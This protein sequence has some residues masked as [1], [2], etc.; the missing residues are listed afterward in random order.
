M[1]CEFPPGAL[2]I[3]RLLTRQTGIQSLD[4]LEISASNVAGR[5]TDD[6]IAERRGVVVFGSSGVG[7][8][9]DGGGLTAFG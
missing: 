1:V 3:I 9:G 4:P 2:Q 8:G 6:R 7:N 5:P